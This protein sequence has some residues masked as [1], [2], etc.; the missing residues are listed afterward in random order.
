MAWDEFAVEAHLAWHSS[1]VLVEHIWLPEWEWGRLAAAYW[2]LS[3]GRSSLWGGERVKA[4]DSRPGQKHVVGYMLVASGEGHS[5]TARPQKTK[6]F[7]RRRFPIPPFRKKPVQFAGSMSQLP[8]GCS[9][10]KMEGGG[11]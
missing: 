2:S 5:N 4:T 1:A 10:V 3:L 6:L 8:Q 9:S 7:R 11:R